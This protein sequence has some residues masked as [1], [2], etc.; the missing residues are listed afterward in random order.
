MTLVRAIEGHRQ[1]V[2]W[3]SVARPKAK[4]S[5][6]FGD[7]LNGRSIISADVFIEATQLLYDR[8]GA[9]QLLE[10]NLLKR[11]IRVCIEH[12]MA[13]GTGSRDVP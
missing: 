1:M 11:L 9:P 7:L 8:N 10:Q 3:P 5:F 2:P 13:I 4:R 12:N 6:L